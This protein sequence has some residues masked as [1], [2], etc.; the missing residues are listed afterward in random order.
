[1]TSSGQGSH[2]LGTGMP[3]ELLGGLDLKGWIV[4]RRIGPV[5][6]GDAAAQPCG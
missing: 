6:C 2:A 4:M 1:M 5:C 3:Q